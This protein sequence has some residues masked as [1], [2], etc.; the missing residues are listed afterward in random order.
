MRAAAIEH[1][2]VLFGVENVRW[3]G[4]QE[5]GLAGFP[6][7]VRPVLETSSCEVAQGQQD[8]GTGIEC[9]AVHFPA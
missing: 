4:F 8:R 2:R 7:V 5:V 3:H 6:I 1:D 9:V